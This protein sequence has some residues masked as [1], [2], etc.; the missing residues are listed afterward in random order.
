M[1]NPIKHLTL[2]PEVQK[3]II[4]DRHLA[5]TWT[6]LIPNP[7]Y[8]LFEETMLYLFDLL[9]K[10][11]PSRVLDTGSGLTSVL[12]RKYLPKTPITTVDNSKDWL[13]KTGELGRRF[14]VSRHNYILWDE[15]LLIEVMRGTFDFIVHDLGNMATRLD[16]LDTVLDYATPKCHILLDNFGIPKYKEYAMKQLTSQGYRPLFPPDPMK[17]NVGNAGG[18]AAFARGQD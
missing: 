6:D 3:S 18:F 10:V 14:N 13:A 8:P 9:F 12:L 5:F 15:F 11:R 16:T 2:D 4:E 17:L 1:S 7:K